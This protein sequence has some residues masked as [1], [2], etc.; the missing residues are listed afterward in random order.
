MSLKISQ[1]KT[2]FMIIKSLIDDNNCAI[3]VAEETEG[4]FTYDS[5]RPDKPEL[6]ASLTRFSPMLPGTP[7]TNKNRGN[8]GHLAYEFCKLHSKE[9]EN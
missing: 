7:E 5:F 1:L 2:K 3:N 8:W 4:K 6:F 9:N